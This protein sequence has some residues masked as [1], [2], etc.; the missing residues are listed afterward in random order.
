MLNTKKSVA[1]ISGGSSD[2]G[3]S[4][5]AKLTLE[6]YGITSQTFIDVGVAG[7]HRLLSQIDEPQ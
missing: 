7:L 5:E 3:V 6:I 4:L 1:I 2:I